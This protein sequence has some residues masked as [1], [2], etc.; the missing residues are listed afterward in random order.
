M[1]FA[2]AAERAWSAHRIEHFDRMIAQEG[3]ARF[4]CG[5]DWIGIGRGVLELGVGGQTRRI[6]VEDTQNIYF[7]QGVLVIEERGAKKGL[8][9]SEGVHRFPVAALNDF[10]VFLVGLEEQTGVRFR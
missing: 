10:Q 9:R 4:A 6:P 3:T 1:Q 2:Y 7:E 5:R 8:F